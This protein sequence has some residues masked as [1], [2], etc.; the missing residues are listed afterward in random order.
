MFAL[1]NLPKEYVSLQTEL[2]GIISGGAE[3]AAA[4]NGVNRQAVQLVDLNADGTSEAIAFFTTGDGLIKAYVFGYGEDKY[5]QTGVLECYGRRIW[6]V[7]YPVCSEK[8]ERAIALS[9]T[10]D[11]DVTYG[12]NVASLKDGEL[13]PMLDL[14]YSEALFED[15]DGD[16]CDEI[17]FAVRNGASGAF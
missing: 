11:D 6:S 1:P 7:D 16:G 9:V 15:A 2:N 17:F 13:R 10:F 3:Y 4:E 12:M 14:Q 8:G 5:A